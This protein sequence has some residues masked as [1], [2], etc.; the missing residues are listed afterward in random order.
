MIQRGGKETGNSSFVIRSLL[1]KKVNDCEI[2]FVLLTNGGGI[3]ESE[4]A[5]LIN[6]T[7]GISKN[8]R[9]IEGHHMVL[10]HTPFKSKELVD[11]YSD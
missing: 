8:E 2:P 9:K 1:N 5:D 11:L 7:I 4:R 10:C 6:R 3:P